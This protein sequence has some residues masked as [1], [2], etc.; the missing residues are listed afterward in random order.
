MSHDELPLPVYRAEQVREF[1]RRLIEDH[2][3]A[4]YTLMQRAAAA[5]ERLIGRDWPAAE[6]IVI[7]CGAGNNGGDGYVLAR[8]LSKAGRRVQVISPAD[9]ARLRGDARRAFDD[10]QAAGGSLISAADIDWRDVDLIVDA[11]LGT[12]LD[13]PVEGAWR[14]LIVAID[15]ARAP[16]L[17][18]DI[19]SGLDS[20]TGAVHGIA[21]HAD[22]T[23]S[24]IGLK[25]GLFTAHGPACS[26]RVCFDSLG[27]SEEVFAGIRPQA[28]RITLDDIL[29]R[30]PA[31]AHKGDCG[32][33][34]VVGGNH[35]MS[36]AAR[37]AAEA[38]LR[39]GAGLVSVA[40]RTA[41]AP[42]VSVT[43]PEIMSHGVE[44]AARLAPLLRRASMV[45]IGPGLGR[46]DWARAMLG[47][48]IETGLP[49]VVDADALNLLADDPMRRDNWVLTPHPGEAA[50][51]L[52]SDSTAI[53]D[54]RFAAAEAIREAFGG[55]CVLKGAGTLIAD[56]EAPPGL[57][58]RG[59]PGM[60]SAGMGD[61]LT[62][63][64]ASLA[65]QGLSLGQAA[66]R[67][68]WLHATAADRASA[69]GMRGLLASDLMPEL[70][71]LV[72][73]AGSGEA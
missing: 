12:G 8:L 65:A 1:D 11:L 44:P 22:A 30:R 64:I 55:V 17:A 53:Q 47:C 28:C 32:H 68:V 62:G 59:N 19:P 66:R 24:F 3:I 5:C 49:L 57:C 20:D 72:D 56:G 71:Q 16:V 13:R 52:D 7:A 10:W 61:V 42:L 29:P 70:R 38:A 18:V 31:D 63:V 43:R 15:A 54:D 58:D 39:C 45:A 41:H 27:A 35:G 14:D 34:L 48:V 25:A 69:A 73:D 60:A 36:G 67:G 46:D 21:V 50:R 9:P 26:G 2:G 23:M 51:L 33:V 40:T 6:R 37:L 4:G